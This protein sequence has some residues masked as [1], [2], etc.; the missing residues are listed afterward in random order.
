M[1][2]PRT[3]LFTSHLWG[4]IMLISLWFMA[5]G[6]RNTIVLKPLHLYERVTYAR[7]GVWLSLNVSRKRRGGRDHATDNVSVK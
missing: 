6:T 3:G 5:S 1:N 2:H 4:S 7:S